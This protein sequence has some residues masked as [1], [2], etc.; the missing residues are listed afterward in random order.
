MSEIP[1]NKI[2]KRSSTAGSSRVK[3]EKCGV[4]KRIK[5][6]A[7]FKGKILCS[8]CRPHIIGIAERKEKNK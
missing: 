8:S 3:C 5:F 1:Y 7:R 2:I 4:V 6:M